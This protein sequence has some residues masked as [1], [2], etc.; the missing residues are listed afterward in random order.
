MALG[1]DHSILLGLAS[2]LTGGLTAAVGVGGGV[3]LLAVMA[4]LLPGPAI[5]PLHGLAQAY[6]NGV[7]AGLNRRHIQWPVVS[8]FLVG[9]VLGTILAGFVVVNLPPAAIKIGLGIFVIIQTMGLL[10]ASIF[11]KSGQRLMSSTSIGVMSMFF[12]APGPLV[13]AAIHQMGVDQRHYNGTHAMVMVVLHGSKLATF[14]VLG[15]AFMAY[16]DA[17]IA[18]IIGST[19]GTLIGQQFM[20]RLSPEYFRQGLTWVLILVGVQLVLSGLH[21]IL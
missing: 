5:I 20:T 15:F 1:L 2:F 12:G 21:S 14:L 18:I 6:A 16:L 10:P 13:A 8:A 7:R 11:V 17:I 19:L 9:M 4:S 3:A